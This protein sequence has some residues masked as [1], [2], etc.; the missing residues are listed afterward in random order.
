[1]GEF[2]TPRAATPEPRLPDRH[3]LGAGPWGHYDTRIQRAFYGV[4]N[5]RQAPLRAFEQALLYRLVRQRAHMELFSARQQGL[6][7][8]AAEV[9]EKAL[10]AEFVADLRTEQVEL[11]LHCVT[12]AGRTFARARHVGN[13][14]AIHD[15]LSGRALVYLPGARMSRC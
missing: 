3:D 8:W 11:E 7:D 15:K 14:V 10:N 4:D 12:F 5:P 9:F 13:A 1:M 2:W 6:S